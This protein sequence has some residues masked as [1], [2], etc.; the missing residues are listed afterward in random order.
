ML[1]NRTLGDLRISTQ[2]YIK[3]SN[4][5]DNSVFRR[6]LNKIKI[7]KLIP[8]HF[9][10]SNIKNIQ[11]C[12]KKK[13]KEPYDL[14]R[15]MFKKRTSTKKNSLKPRAPLKERLLKKKKNT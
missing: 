14:T 8:L 5:I 1:T 9:Y 11:S 4:W 2:L 7:K 3:K 12:L 15:N 6:D 10:K 13:L